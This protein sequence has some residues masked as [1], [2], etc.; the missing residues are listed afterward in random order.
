MSK[1][2]TERKGSVFIIS[3]NRCWGVPLIDGGTQRLPRIIGLGNALYLIETGAVINSRQALRMGLTQ[4][5]APDGQALSRAL[6]LAL[7]DLPKGGVH[8]PRVL[9]KSAN[10]G[11]FH[12]QH[13]AADLQKLG[14]Y[15]S[16]IQ[17]HAAR[18]ASMAVDYNDCMGH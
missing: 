2:E 14:D 17:R 1:V 12:I 13:P 6:E 16:L 5:I 11:L 8:H 15:E 3:I 18:K 10:K 4:E 9:C 7:T